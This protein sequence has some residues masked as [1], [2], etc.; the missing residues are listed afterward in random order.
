MERR[1]TINLEMALDMRYGEPPGGHE[2][3]DELRRGLCDFAP[4]RRTA[5]S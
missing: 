2:L 4:P 1:E 5:V 3:E